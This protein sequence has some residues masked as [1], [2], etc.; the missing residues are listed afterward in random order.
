MAAALSAQA[1]TPVRT[2]DY[3]VAV[4]NAEV[5]THKEVEQRAVR[6]AQEMRNARTTVPGDAALYQQALSSLIDERV[7]ITHARETGVRIDET[8]LDRNV[9]TIASVNQLTVEA[10]RERLRAEG[11][12]FARFR[13]NLSDQLLA[14][15]V[16]ERDVLPRIRVSEADVDAFLGEQRTQVSGEVQLNIAQ[17]FVSV[18]EGANAATVAQRQALVDMTLARLRS[19]EPFDRL[20]KELSE[21]MERSR[22]GEIGLR[23]SSRLPDVFVDTVRN[24][25]VGQFSPR[26]VRSSAGFHILKL[27]ARQSESALN[28][29]QTR[30]RH[31][32]LRPSA[33]LSSDEAVRRMGE[34]RDQVA[35]GKRSFEQL[36]Q[37]YSEDGS[38]ARGGDLGWLSPGQLVP[39]FEKAMNALGVGGVSAPVLSRFGVH[40]IQVVDRRQVALDPRQVREQARNAV[41]E[42]KFGQ[43]YAE[44]IDE[45]RSRAYIELRDPPL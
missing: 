16:R 6:M 18:P 38:A 4:V 3:I 5:V 28:V 17:I 21:G 13:A 7:V 15:R 24:L 22:G 2:A 45:L 33:G 40:L 39:E 9:Q 43:T 34:F 11:M 26:V 10:L 30:A 8:E 35:Q 25:A 27:L 42:R 44:W 41:R 32:L 36:A 12:D 29:T 14:D 31:I 19:G 37:Q 1:Q 20:A 23:P